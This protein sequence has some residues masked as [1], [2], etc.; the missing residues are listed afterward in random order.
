[1]DLFF[2]CFY[3][4][5]KFKTDKNIYNNG[6]YNAKKRQPEPFTAKSDRTKK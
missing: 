5:M 6:N 3:L 4:G 2:Y 1:M